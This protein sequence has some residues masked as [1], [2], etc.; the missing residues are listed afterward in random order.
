MFTQDLHA[1][2]ETPKEHDGAVKRLGL[3]PNPFSL[4]PN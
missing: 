3:S 2:Y 4:W 1:L